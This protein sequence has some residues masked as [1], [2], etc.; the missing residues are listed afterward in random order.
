MVQFQHRVLAYAILAALALQWWRTRGEGPAHKALGVALALAVAQAALGV[1]TVLNGVPVAL[2][3]LHQ[4][5]ALVLLTAA[6]AGAWASGAAH[7]DM[8]RRLP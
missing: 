4:A 2:G 1:L 5:G 7:A 8:L 3:L 6:L